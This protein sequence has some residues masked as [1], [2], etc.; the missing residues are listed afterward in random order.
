MN[1]NSIT[2]AT[3]SV[4]VNLQQSIKILKSPIG[5]KRQETT[6]HTN[7]SPRSDLCTF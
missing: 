4:N 1:V 6:L 3:I 5:L 2:T 7:D